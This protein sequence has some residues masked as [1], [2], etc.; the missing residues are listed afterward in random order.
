MTSFDFSGIMDN[1]IVEVEENPYSLDNI[2]SDIV[3]WVK[4]SLKWEEGNWTE[5]EKFILKKKLMYC[6]LRK[7]VH[8][9]FAYKYNILAKYIDIPKIILSS[10]LSTSLFV[11]ASEDE[12]FST[13]MQYVN[14][15]LSTSLALMI[16]LNSYV[17]FGDKYTEHRT[18]SLEYGKLASEIERLLQAPIDERSSFSST[19]ADIDKKYSQLRDDAPF[20]PKKIRDLYINKINTN[21]YNDVM[22]ITCRTKINENIEDDDEEYKKA[23]EYDKKNT[24][25]KQKFKPLILDALDKMRESDIKKNPKENIRENTTENIRENTTEKIRENTTENIRENKID[26][27]NDEIKLDIINK[28]VE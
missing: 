23:D 14:A 22:N 20:I 18:T 4:A 24:C 26:N 13:T 5:K 3:Y 27:N 1:S 9:D 8:W 21:E 17:K 10:I 28:E 11:N 6:Y 15:G 7:E 25:K 12:S 19:L 2:K 16:G